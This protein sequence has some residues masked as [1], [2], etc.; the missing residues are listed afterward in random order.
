MVLK[1]ESV[2]GN[3]SELCHINSHRLQDTMHCFLSEREREGVKNCCFSR[4]ACEAQEE[5]EDLPLVFSPGLSYFW[6]SQSSNGLY[7]P[8][9]WSKRAEQAISVAFAESSYAG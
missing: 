8:H 1:R 2:R 7:V 6:R 9:C 3:A 4:L 5:K